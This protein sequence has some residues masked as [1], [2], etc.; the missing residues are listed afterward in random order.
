VNA[1]P[2][3]VTQCN[4]M[5]SLVDETYF[6]RAWCAVEASMMQT[7]VTSYG[8]HDWYLDKLSSP[9]FDR[10]TGVLERSTAKVD[11]DPSNLP[12]SVPSDRPIVAF[13]HK[14]SILLGKAVS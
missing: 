5:I 7:L 12:V 13:L 9:D 1:L 3:S 2:I 10:V 4:A 8:Q 11:V 14:Q 6:N